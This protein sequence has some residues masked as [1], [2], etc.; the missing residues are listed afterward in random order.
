MRGRLSRGERNPPVSLWLT[1]PFTRGPLGLAM[2]APTGLTEVQSRRAVEGA[3]P[4][5]ID[6][7]Y[8]I[9]IFWVKNS[10]VNNKA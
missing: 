10:L 5:R 6:F 7:R 3:G 2:L 9:Y 1:A 8:S 4:Y